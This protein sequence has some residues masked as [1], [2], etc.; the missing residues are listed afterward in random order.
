MKAARLA[1][2]LTVVWLVAPLPAQGPEFEVASIK[3]N[4]GNGL[5]PASGGGQVAPSGPNPVSGQIDLINVPARAMVLSAYPV[6]TRPIEVL[7]LPAWADSERY[8][9]MARARP[10]SSPMDLQQMWRTLLSERMK[11]SAH[12]ETRERPGYNLVFAREDRRLG[13]QLTPADCRKSSTEPP[14]G[15]MR[16]LS[17]RTPLSPDLERIFMSRCGA[18]LSVG[19]TIY[20]SGITFTDVLA[21]ITRA[22]GRSVVNRTGL[23]GAY[24]LKLTFAQRPPVTPALDDPPS[25]FTALQE[26][27]GLKLESATTQGRVLVVDQIER[28]S[29]N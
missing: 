9:V 11:L 7:G 14:E 24:S 16:A 6:D 17:Q 28:P 22:V 10:G 4:L 25:I 27:L 1:V 3:R 21:L 15:L 12:Y 18:R 23:E 26:Q 20:A 5:P 8:D 29:E 2:V 13:A 19:D